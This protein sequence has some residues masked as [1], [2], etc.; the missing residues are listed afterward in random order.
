MQS[1]QVEEGESPEAVAAGLGINR[2]TIYRWL[3]AYQSGGS[4]AL[5]AKPIPGAPTKLSAQEMQELAQ[6]LREHTPLDFGFEA[7]L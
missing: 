2:R 3:Q 6:L 7:A 4:D 5:A 1:L